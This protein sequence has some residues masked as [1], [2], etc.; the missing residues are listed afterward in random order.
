MTREILFR[1]KRLDNG[2]WIEGYLWSERTIGHTSPCGDTDKRIVDPYTVSQYTGLTDMNGIK[3][4]EG[5]IVQEDSGNYRLLCHLE[6]E[7]AERKHIGVIAF[8][9][10]DTPSWD[11]FCWGNTYGYYIDGDV[12]SP[13]LTADYGDG[14]EYNIEVIGNIHDNPELVG[15]DNNA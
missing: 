6:P 5:D 10:H 7:N 12:F 3:I 15:E 1:G 14:K 4:F 2:K 8:G 13:S 9:E 11:P